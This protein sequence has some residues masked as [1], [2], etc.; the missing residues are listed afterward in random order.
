ML[1]YQPM[2]ATEIAEEAMH[3]RVALL[4]LAQNVL[5][6][7]IEV[8][9]AQKA[10]PELSANI[11]EWSLEDIRELLPL[12]DIEASRITP[13]AFPGLDLSLYDCEKIFRTRIAILS[14][15][16]Q[17]SPH[18]MTPWQFAGS[19]TGIRQKLNHHLTTLQGTRDVVRHFAGLATAST[20]ARSEITE[21]P[22]ENV[23]W[24]N[25]EEWKELRATIA[26]ASEKVQ[27][28][29]MMGN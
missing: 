19:L 9:L 14:A 13:D 22:P 23:T 5:T 6:D 29:V 8:E 2:E 7:T 26:R 28:E 1:D 25:T 4:H 24:G 17:E 16:L 10:M 18:T 15:L 12:L 11:P 27:K 20:L 21:P 3:E